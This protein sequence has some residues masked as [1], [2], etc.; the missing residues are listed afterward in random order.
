MNVLSLSSM[1]QTPVS[2]KNRDVSVTALSPWGLDAFGEIIDESPDMQQQKE[3]LTQRLTDTQKA[4]LVG[5]FCVCRKTADCMKVFLSVCIYVLSCVPCASLPCVCVL[6]R[7]ERG[8]QC[9]YSFL[10]QRQ[11]LF[12][13][14]SKEH[15]RVMR[16]EPQRARL[17]E[18]SSK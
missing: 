11:I 8:D 4:W 18:Y 7:E 12:L 9:D 14:S 5:C 10:C 13:L 1:L 6:I 16:H 2:L 15:L 3:H 17:S